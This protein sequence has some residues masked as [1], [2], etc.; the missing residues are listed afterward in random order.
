[1]LILTLLLILYNKYHCLTIKGAQL[2]LFELQRGRDNGKGL[3]VRT[4]LQI[5]SDANRA[6]RN[7]ADTQKQ[8]IPTAYNPKKS[9]LF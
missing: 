3:T 6:C 8:V 4:Y 7:I 2:A 5:I 1:M 9:A